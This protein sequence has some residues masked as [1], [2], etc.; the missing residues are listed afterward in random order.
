MLYI[1]VDGGGTKTKFTLFDEHGTVLDSYQAGT[2]HYAQVGYDG[3]RHVIKKGVKKLLKDH[4]DELVAIGLGLAGYGREEAVREK[5]EKSIE[6]ALDGHQWILKSDVDTAL[7]GALNNQPGILVIAGTGSIA[8]AKYSDETTSRTGGW[9][10]LVGD[11]GS[12]YWIGRQLLEAFSKQSDGRWPK[13]QLYDLVKEQLE[14]ENDADL[15]SYVLQ[16]LEGKREKIA[17]LAMIVGQ[18]ATQK[19]ETALAIYDRAAA[20]LALMVNTLADTFPQQKV[21]ASF[22]GG[23]FKAGDVLMAPFIRYL[24]EKVLLVA[25]QHEPD[26]GA[27]LYAKEMMDHAK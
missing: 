8:L 23:A 7:K 12:A 16:T 11:E 17:Q 5:M 1:G 4:P 6:K 20:E 18:A 19:D 21:L 26:F 22:V 25:P 24:H 2:C 27:Y 14:L 9:G 13:T 10:Y 3:L 15:I